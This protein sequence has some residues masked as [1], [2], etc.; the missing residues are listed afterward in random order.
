MVNTH[1]GRDLDQRRAVDALRVLHRVERGRH[2]RHRRQEGAD[3]AEAGD[4][5]REEMA[6]LV[7]RELGGHLVVAA[8][9]VGDEAAGALVGPLHRAAERA[10]GV[11]RQ[12]Y[13]GKIAAFMPNEPP[14][15]QVSTRTFSGATP[16]I[17]RVGPA[18]RTRPAGRREREALAVVGADRRA[19][20]HG[21]DD[22]RVC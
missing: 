3:V 8:V 6:V 21:G 18:G 1:L 4:A 15:L 16:R 2:R 12:T 11:R 17:R 19:R 5:H 22:E 9:V 13:S 10:R 14:T 7:E 20:L